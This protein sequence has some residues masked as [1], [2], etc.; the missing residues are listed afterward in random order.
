MS[1]AA[2]L[3]LYGFAVAV[4]APKLLRSVNHAGAVPHV[5]LAAWLGAIASTVL[6]WAI[7]LAVLIIDI[8]THPFSIT[9]RHFVDSCLLHLHDALIGRYGLPVQTGLLLLGGFAGLAATI[10]ATR[11]GTTLFRARRNT[12]EHGRLARMAGRHHPDLDAVV[13][14]VDEPA[15]YCVAGK[16]HT[17]VVSRGVLAVLDEDQLDAVLAHERAHLA[18][19]H[20]LLLALTRSFAAVMPRISLFTIGA[21]EVARLLEM[22]ADDAAARIHGRPV[23]LGALRTLAGIATGPTGSLGAAEVG[24]ESRVRR[25]EGP[26]APAALRAKTR[27]AF[28]AMTAMATLVPLAAVLTAAIGIAVCAPIPGGGH[29]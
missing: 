15:A 3:A 16:P 8:V 10:C 29:L 25:L 13:L 14:E 22:I 17:V 18:G 27:L 9:P 11:L 28:V 7:A 4:L 5:A 12:L 21:R 2:C 23:V 1:V 19:R 6:A 26:T 20:H 24:I